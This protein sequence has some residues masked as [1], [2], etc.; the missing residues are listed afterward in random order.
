MSDP[1]EA[2]ARLD[3]IDRIEGVISNFIYADWS[4]AMRES[5]IVG[6][7]VE[8]ARTL[9]GANR[10]RIYVTRQSGWSGADVEKFL[11]H[12]A[13]PVWDRGFT[14]PEVYFSVKERQANWAEYLMLRRG[15]PVAGRL[16]NP[17]NVIYGQQHA[18]GDQPPA[19]ADQP[20]GGRGRSKRS[21]LDRL[22]DLLL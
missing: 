6:I 20:D 13:V 1:L 22:L 5:G 21:T 12:Y 11:R 8:F 2:L 7:V 18:P 19:W 10:W 3:V 17:R 15:I 9:V 14:G 4:G 16:Y